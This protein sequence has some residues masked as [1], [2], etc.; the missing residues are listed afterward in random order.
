MQR[1]IN[2]ENDLDHDV[3]GDVVERQVV[4]VSREKELHAVNEMK[5]RKAFGFSIASMELIAARTVG[6]QVMTEI[7]QKILDEFG[8]PAEWALS[9]VAQSSRGNVIFRTVAAIEM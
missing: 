6:N 1:I 7:C 8:I 5:T 2:E 9:I 3:E 4:C